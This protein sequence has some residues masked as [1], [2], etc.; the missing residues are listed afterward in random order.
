MNCTIGPSNPLAI[1][2]ATQFFCWHAAVGGV[3][4]PAPIL[5]PPLALYCERTLTPPYVPCILLQLGFVPA[6]LCTSACC[7]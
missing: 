2:W 4:L 3:H 5:L 1:K 7:A 6:A